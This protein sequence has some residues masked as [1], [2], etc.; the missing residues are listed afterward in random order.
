M[1]VLII[2]FCT[3]ESL[4]ESRKDFK[5]LL[6]TSTSCK[7]KELKVVHKVYIQVSISYLQIFAKTIVMPKLLKRF[8]F[9]CSETS[10][11]IGFQ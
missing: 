8:A 9:R 1:T 4:E 11:P 7:L 10:K 3:E 2:L 6:P 5:T